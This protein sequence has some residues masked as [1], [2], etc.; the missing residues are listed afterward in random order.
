[1]FLL[2]KK[3]V[4]VVVVVVVDVG[5]WMLEQQGNKSEYGMALLF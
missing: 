4:V 1:M 3:F 2:S 5:C